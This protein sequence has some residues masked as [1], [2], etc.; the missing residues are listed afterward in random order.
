LIFSNRLPPRVD[1]NAISAA[2]AALRERSIGF[3][4][5][6]ES[7]PTAAGLPYPPDLLTP[8]ADSR[9]LSYEPHPFGLA[10]ARQAIAADHVR[11]GVRVEAD[12]V[13]L[14]ASTSESYSWLFKLLCNPGDTVLAPRPSYPLFEHLTR[15]EGVELGGY[16]LQYHGRWEIDR[17]SLRD[18]PPSTRAVLLV[19]PNNPTGSY[20]SPGDLDVVAMLCRER[21]W[22]L[23]ADEV[24]ADY[25]LDEGSP[26]TDI[27]ARADVLAFTLGGAS[28]SLGLPQVKLGWIVVGGPPSARAA[29]LDALALISD[30]YLSVGTPVQVAAPELLQGGADI[31]Q[32]IH[33]RVR[34]NLDRARSIARRF[35]ACEV[36]RVEGGWMAPIRVP[37]TRSE[38]QLVLGLLDHERIL[39]HPGYFFDFPHEAFVVVSL[40][41]DPDRFADALERTLRYANC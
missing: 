2:V 5:L 34:A 15:L 36:L 30:T 18:A 27:A 23:I 32:A 26:L 6:T 7:N 39:V 24:F 29:A 41:L 9:S 40:L 22:A 21:G 14:S 1:A 13:V 17:Q 10:S 8:L 38:E 12:A 25:P 20:V 4:D 31:R 28:K 11:R 3:I 37:A 16:A 19:S 35:P 33:A